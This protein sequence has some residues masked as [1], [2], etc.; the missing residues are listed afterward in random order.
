MEVYEQVMRKNLPFL[1]VFLTAILLVCC[2]IEVPKEIVLSGKNGYFDVIG[3]K[4]QVIGNETAVEFWS[5]PLCLFKNYTIDKELGTIAKRP[6]SVTRESKVLKEEI[7]VPLNEDGCVIVY[8]SNK[9]CRVNVSITPILE[10]S[11]PT[12]SPDVWSPYTPDIENMNI[13]IED[14]KMIFRA[15][16]K[17]G[18]I[19]GEGISVINATFLSFELNGR[20]DKVVRIASDEETYDAMENW[21]AMLE[22][23]KDY[24]ENFLSS[25]TTIE[26]PDEK[27]NNAY[28]WNLI[29]LDNCYLEKPDNGWVAGY[30]LDISKNGRPGFAWYFGRDFL[31]MSFAMVTCGDFEKAKDGF[32]LLQKFQR[33]DGKI[34]HELAAPINEIGKERWERDFPYY[35]AAA[36]ST[37]L[38]FI[39]LDYYMRCSGDEAFIVESKD[40]I[41]KA[42]TY[43]LKTDIDGD[44]LIDNLAG[45]GWVEGGFL[46]KDQ[47][48][49][50]HTTL[51][52]ASLWLES[53]KSAK[54]LFDLLGERKLSAQC[55]DL[56]T[57]VDIYRFRD[58]EGG[59]F[60]HRKL[61]DGT[62]GKEKTVMGA[63]P[64]LFG[65]ISENAAERELELLNSQEITAPWGCRIVSNRDKNYNAT[66]YHE[67]SVWPLF[68]GWVALANFRYN[69]YEEGLSLVKKNLILIYNLGLGYA[70]EVMGGDDFELLG[71]PHQGWSSSMTIFPAL[72]GV[73]GIDVN[74]R[75]KTIRLSPYVP[76]EWNFLKIKN[77]RCGDN[78]FN[79]TL[80]RKGDEI[81]YD[82]EGDTEGYTIYLSPFNASHPTK[83]SI[84]GNRYEDS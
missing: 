47:I 21:K 18:I 74:E 76:E 58:E 79:V 1:T 64:L 26:T 48:K 14:G 38:Y 35:F 31:W 46:A 34:M 27:L 51:Y 60:Y 56:I 22:G 77:I 16:D 71:C 11:W 67:G 7:F 75:N 65:Q 82:I 72:K 53:L 52:L 69:H 28:L 32:R 6:W 49:A 57:S 13:S 33:G 24:Y 23:T 80:H 68:T 78:R 42:F 66:G 39:A 50:G 61:P 41:V 12:Y 5:M 19:G 45:H 63:M 4:M 83:V 36:D 84:F 70:P 30:N 54:D 37:P 15:G 62:F 9:S 44:G 17:G 43:L 2:C 25:V 20:D 59:Y 29:A 10:Y 55:K 8:S 40:S 81:M 3:K 73:A